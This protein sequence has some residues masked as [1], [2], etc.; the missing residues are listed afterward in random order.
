MFEVEMHNASMSKTDQ[1]LSCQYWAS[2]YTKI[3]K[4]AGKNSSAVFGNAFHKC[5][6][7]YLTDKDFNVG[8]VASK[9]GVDEKKLNNYFDRWVV[10]IE[11]V[12]KEN[13]WETAT[14]LVE[15][16]L[17]YNPFTDET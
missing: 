13:G 9:Y 16:K 6:E 5:T 3:P 11:K 14:K 10:V 4:E 7:L 12:F 2:P 15:Q 17:A 8:I 1:L